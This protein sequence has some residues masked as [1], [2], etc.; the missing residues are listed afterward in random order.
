MTADHVH[1][2]YVRMNVT[3]SIDEAVVERARRLAE[4]R[5]TSMNQL[6]RDYLEEVT[7]SESPEAALRELEKMWAEGRGRST[8]EV[9]KRED[10]YDRPVLR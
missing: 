7:A 9:W 5:G 4:R 3:L 2:Y 6:I 8:G 10:L 1:T